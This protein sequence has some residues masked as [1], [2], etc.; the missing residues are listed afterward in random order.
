MSSYLNDD[1][2]VEALKDWW[3]EN[4][5]AV[6]IGAILG[7]SSVIGW[8]G[9]DRYQTSQNENASILFSIMESQFSG[10]ERNE[11]ITSA[12]SLL[13]TYPNTIYAT[14]ASFY[15]GKMY[16]ELE[17]YEVARTYLTLA[18]ENASDSA[19]SE[20]AKLRLVR[21]LVEMQKFEEAELI[22]TESF[23]IF[24]GE[25]SEIIGDLAAKNNNFSKARQ[26]YNRA[27]SQ[28]VDNAD[29]LKMK[30]ANLGKDVSK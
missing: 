17:N 9:W 11:G 20:L 13:E 18:V 21:L 19:L 1:E 30:I 4:G 26:A 27:L 16:R 22:L 25:F 3:K 5:R 29:L 14:F 24:K 28:G 6:I 8:Q 23:A 10:N 15:L 7:I 12:K 2:Q